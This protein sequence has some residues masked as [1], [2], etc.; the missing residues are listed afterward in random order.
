[1]KRT[2]GLFILFAVLL[3]IIPQPAY[4]QE[5]AWFKTIKVDIGNETRDVKVVWIDMK[6]PMYRAEVA[7]ANGQAG[8]VDSFI[9]I[10]EQLSDNETEVVAAINGTFFN[11]NSDLQ[12]T[13]TIRLQ[14]RTAFFSNL[15]TCIGF[16][17]NNEIEFA[18][19]YTS[20]SGSIN[21]NWEYP[22]NW[23][24]WGINQNYTQE[25]ADIMYTPDFGKEVD[26][27][28]KSAIIIR[29][30]SVTAIQKGISPIYSDGYTLVIGSPTYSVMFKVGD[31]IDCRVNTNH[32]DHKIA[33]K[34]GA[35]L[36]WSHIRTAL[37]AGPMLVNN[38]VIVL[39]SQQEGFTDVKFTTNRAQRS[40]IGE[41]ENGILV[42]GTVSSVTFYELATALKNMNIINGMNLDG[43][44]SSGLYYGGEL[45]TAPSRKLSNAIVITKKKTRPARLQLNGKELFFDTDPYFENNTTMVPMR[46][47]AEALGA[48]A[49][50]D[51]ETGTLW[52]VKG[53]TKVEMW[54]NSKLIKVNGVEQEL[55][56]PVKVVY[57]RTH[58]PAR[59]MTEIFGG[60]IYFDYDNYM[61]VMSMDNLDANETYIRAVSKLD[62]GNTDEALK[63]FSKVLELDPAHAGAMLKLARHYGSTW[64]NEK[65]K[66]YYEQFL[67]I[68]PDDLNVWN[69]L[70][71]TYANLGDVPKAL[72]VF[73][74]LTQKNPQTA[75]YWSALGDMYAH[76]Q[77]QD[78]ANARICYEKALTCNL[79]DS[80]KANL[81]EK[82]KK[83]AE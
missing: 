25:N 8:Q 54:N 74:T 4:A 50:W 60:S 7:L 33:E 42:I 20:V 23:S 31:K 6:D 53:D 38:G 83:L 39:N 67:V 48:E 17:G 75:A 80:M 27:G 65:A 9:N 36:D 26:A 1:M 66:T 2:I 56:A 24:V 19:L 44:A 12:P 18:H 51:S 3:S 29:N 28:S 70:G 37:G 79:S 63:L 22:Y 57:N 59:F 15:G 52:M 14:G 5:K 32:I 72:Q 11:A 55:L 76:Y 40:F 45:L 49:G 69:S 35:E 13:G 64:E 43:G 41:M 68:Q 71:W 73:E 34:K 30:G 46:G 62:S 21:G 47:I 82:L 16:T 78:V 61:V 81:N 58:V 77:L 10:A